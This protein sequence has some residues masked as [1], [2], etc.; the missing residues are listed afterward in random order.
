MLGHGFSR[1][2]LA[3][4]IR[5]KLSAAEREVVKAGGETIEISRTRIT[6]VGRQAIEG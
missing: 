3:G 5:R 1:W 4:L 2:L 6:K